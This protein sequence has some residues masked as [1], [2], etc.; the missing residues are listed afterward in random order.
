MITSLILSVIG[1]AF[2]T[3]LETRKLLCIYQ[4]KAKNKMEMGFKVIL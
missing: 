1:H 3:A 4:K 2:K